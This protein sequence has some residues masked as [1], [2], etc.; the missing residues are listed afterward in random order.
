MCSMYRFISFPAFV[1]LVERKKERYVSPA[2]WEDT[3]EGFLLRLLEKEDDT[4]TVLKELMDNVSPN[5][6]EAAVS[7]YYKMWSARWLSYGQCWTTLD[8][9]DAFWRIYSYDRMA[10]RIETDESLIQKI[11]SDEQLSDKYHLEI[12]EVLYDLDLNGHTKT[13]SELMQ[14]I[15]KT[16][17]TMEPYYHKRKA[18]EHEHERRVLLLD[19]DS[20]NYLMGFSAWAVINNFRINNKGKNLTFEEAIRS[21]TDEICKIKIPI[22]KQEM[23]DTVLIDIPDINTYIKSVMVH[24]QAEKWIVELVESIC[25][26]MGLT[27]LG[28]S[29]M[30]EGIQ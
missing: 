8:E 2:T 16:K 19:K 14:E 5:N 17:R 24:P 26:R 28:K 30:Y 13:R 4:E 20:S 1:N 3:H 6:P 27:F 15:H 7:N 22:N 18:F 21:L 9:S 11:F 23:Q 25:K 29:K 12:C 10:I